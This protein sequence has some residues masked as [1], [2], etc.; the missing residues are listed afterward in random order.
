MTDVATP[1]V[2]G[3]VREFS[4]HMATVGGDWRDGND[5]RKED[6]RQSWNP[7]RREFR[8]YRNW[9][10][11]EASVAGQ[12]YACVFYLSDLIANHPAIAREM[13]VQR[14]DRHGA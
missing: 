5:H 11:D 10:T 1:R 12:T 9:Y 4:W 3:G 14:N 13:M 7:S 2:S 8:F 6:H